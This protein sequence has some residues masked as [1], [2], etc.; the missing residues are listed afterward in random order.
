MNFKRHARSLSRHRVRA[1][2][3]IPLL[4]AWVWTCAGVRALPQ[5]PLPAKPA[6]AAEDAK[7]AEPEAPAW[8]GIVMEVARN[9]DADE[10]EKPP[11]GVG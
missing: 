7:P 8:L 10:D 11:P 4:V 3:L 9:L 1:T 6:P 5:E 2:A